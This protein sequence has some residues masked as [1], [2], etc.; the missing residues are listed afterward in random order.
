[1]A[2]PVRTYGRIEYR[3]R[4]ATFRV[5]T[6]RDPIRMTG[7]AVLADHATYAAAAD[8]LREYVIGRTA[9]RGN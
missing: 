9:E 7:P 3:P 5:V 8:A 6:F 2:R 4:S 1:M